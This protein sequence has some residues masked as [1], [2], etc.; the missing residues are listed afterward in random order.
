[1]DKIAKEINEDI[2]RT[3]IYKN[4]LICK[5]NLEKNE[6]LNELKTTLEI[7]KNINCKDKDE[8]LISDYYEIEKEYKSNILVKEYEKSKDDV[9][10]LLKEIS[11]ILSLN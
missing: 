4:Y 2:K 11:D 7:I 8:K 10:S 3:E 9:Y 6:Y 5:E 1:V